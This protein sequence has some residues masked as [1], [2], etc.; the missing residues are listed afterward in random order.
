[1]AERALHLIWEWESQRRID[2]ESARRWELLLRRPLREI[3][4][5]IVAETHSSDDLRQNSPFDGMLSEAERRRIFN[6]VR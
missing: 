6:E 4:A 2:P 3:R 5:E 1:M